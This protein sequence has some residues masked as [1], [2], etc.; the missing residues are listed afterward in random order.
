MKLEWDFHELFDFGDRLVDTAE[1]DVY[2][3]AV[4][5]EIAEKLHKMLIQNTPF[6]FGTL[7][8]FWQTSE[9]YA[10]T[11][12]RKNNGYEV[13]LYN[14]AKYATWVNDGHKQ[15][16]GRFIPGYWEGSRFRYDPTASE[17]M[18]LKKSW[19]FGKYFVERSVVQVAEGRAIE[20][21]LYEQLQKWF[22]WCVNG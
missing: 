14:R 18:V 8:A 22:R 12:E 16:P 7:Q 10:Y 1:F 6:D 13:T 3:T 15:R 11:V 4:A 21:S 20:N 17:G 5:K 2:M 9:N 19:V